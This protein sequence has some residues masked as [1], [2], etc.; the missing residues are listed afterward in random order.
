MTTYRFNQN[1]AL[2]S[3]KG[4][5][6]KSNV[7]FR[8]LMAVLNLYKRQVLACFPSIPDQSG[9]YILTRFENGFKYAY[10][11]QAQKILT[12]L[13]VHLKGFQSKSTQHID[14]SLK[15]HGLYST[16]N[17]TGWKIEY[18]LFPV[19]ELND[20]EQEFIRLYAEKGYQ[21]RNKTSGSQDN[22][23]KAISD[24]VVKGY[25]MGLYKGYEKARKYIA[26]LFDKNLE[27]NYKGDRTPTKNQEKAM[28]KFNE[29]IGRTEENYGVD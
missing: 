20:R 9:I 6:M 21:L 1:K 26:H 18:L 15:K 11:G 3:V 5:D 28:I 12:R 23:K 17:E 27:C 4:E 2:I 7:N 13:A 16:D 29:F 24:T 10:I 19:E 8:Q 22:S 25:Q 14:L